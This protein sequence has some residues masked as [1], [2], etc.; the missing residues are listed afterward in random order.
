M[1]RRG[2]LEAEIRLE[3]WLAVSAPQRQLEAEVRHVEKPVAACAA[4]IYFAQC[5]YQ[6]PE[7]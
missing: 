6:G 4:D 1:A 2:Q 7:Q 5:P 3:V